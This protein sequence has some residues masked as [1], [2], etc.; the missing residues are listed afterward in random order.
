MQDNQLEDVSPLEEE[1]NVKP[2]PKVRASLKWAL[3]S[4]IVIFGVGL[5]TIEYLKTIPSEY[6]VQRTGEIANV[7][8]KNNMALIPESEEDL[9]YPAANSDLNH[10]SFFYN[11]KLNLWE[12]LYISWTEP[13][14]TFIK[15]EDKPNIATG[16]EAKELSIK[17]SDA[18]L[19]AAYN[20]LSK[21]QK[22]IL[23]VF[24]VDESGPLYEKDLRSGDYISHINDVPVRGVETIAEYIEENPEVKDLAFSLIR[25]NT[26]RNNYDFFKVITP[27]VKKIDELGFLGFPTPYIPYTYQFNNPSMSGGSV[28]LI[29]AIA[30]V[31]LLGADEV[32]LFKG[33]IGGTGG[34]TVEG[35]VLKVVGVHQKALTA[36]KNGVQLFIVP[37]ENCSELLKTG[38]DLS[39]MEVHGVS[40]L[41]EAISVVKG[42]EDFT[43]KK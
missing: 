32:T 27:N 8:D 12:Q 3:G 7:Y 34:I 15:K 35:E 2:T 19:I 1:G 36:M 43:C 38:I 39:G 29:S 41:A 14:A 21:E 16:D 10:V 24:V 37:K 4:L 20:Y 5:G 13:T 25:L 40:T 30:A 18:A 17:T 23:Q 9:L 28:G 26:E 6:V 11:D 31:E 22:A 33:K 42:T